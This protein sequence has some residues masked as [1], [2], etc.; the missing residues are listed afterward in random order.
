MDMDNNNNNNNNDCNNLIANN[1]TFDVT[2]VHFYKNKLINIFSSFFVK[3]FA[4]LK[5]ENTDFKYVLKK[6]QQDSNNDINLYSKF[7]SYIKK[8]TT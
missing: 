6:I 8:N 5:N 4:N 2:I 7:K 3:L 1:I